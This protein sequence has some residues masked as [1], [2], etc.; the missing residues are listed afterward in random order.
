MV[1]VVQFVIAIHMPDY[2]NDGLDDDDRVDY[3]NRAF[4]I[5]E[6]A[7]EELSSALKYEIGPGWRAVLEV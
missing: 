5:A 3:E 2:E 7:A 1:S 6:E 4:E